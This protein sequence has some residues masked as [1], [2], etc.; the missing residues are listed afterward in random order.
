MGSRWGSKPATVLL[1]D[2]DRLL[3]ALYADE[4][5]QSVEHRQRHIKDPAAT[6]PVTRLDRLKAI[7]QTILP[8]R[9]LVVLDGDLQ[10]E[11]D[12]Q[13][14]GTRYSPSELSDGERVIF[15]LLGQ[16]LLVKQDCVLIIDEPELHIHKSILARFWDAIESERRDCAFVYLTH[17]LEFAAT[18][19]GAQNFLVSTYSP[20][21]NGQWTTEPIPED[22]AFP[23]EIATKILGSRAPVPF[24]EGVSGSLDAAI[25]RRVYADRTVVP[26]GSCEQVIHAVRTFSSNPAL[27]R[28]ACAGI[29]DADDRTGAEISELRAHG[30]HVLPVSEVENAL[31]LPNTFKQIAAALG[32]SPQDAATKADSLADHVLNEA[33]ADVDRFSVDYVRRRIDR[34]MKTMGLP[35]RDLAALDAEFRGAVSGIDPIAMG[36]QIHDR[37]LTYVAARD[38]TQVLSL[39]DNKGLLARAAT[40]VGLASKKAF[41]EFIGRILRA[42]AGKALLDEL[43]RSLPAIGP[44]APAP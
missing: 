13:Q 27:H 16:C 33:K 41:E 29:V 18:R 15:Y 39:Y 2:Y 4:N 8:D 38:V 37:M 21:A 5:R 12:G 32:F 34:H 17:D 26:F 31:L 28:L 22:G 40:L 44:A 36:R 19:R 14:P 43:R 11:P 20:A 24:V 9:G 1:N 7:W 3:V 23:E 10:V 6:P 35:G 30:V 25:Y 42:D